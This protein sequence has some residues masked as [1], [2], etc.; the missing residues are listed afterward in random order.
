MVTEES[1]LLELSDDTFDQETKGEGW[2][3]VEFYS[4]RCPHCRA[5]RPVLEQVVSEHT[6]P[7]RFYAAEVQQC[8]EAV[9][10][11]EIM[12]IPSL[13]LLSNGEEVDRHAGS[14][15]ASELEKWLA[16]KTAS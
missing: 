10:R 1:K 5:F 16:E 12:S 11:F 8:E 14:M 2:R 6:G 3:L 7:V 9:K 4:R 13:I 15:T